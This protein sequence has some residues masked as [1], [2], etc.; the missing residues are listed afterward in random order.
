MVPVFQNWDPPNE[1]GTR[2]IK[3]GPAVSRLRYTNKTKTRVWEVMCHWLRTDFVYNFWSYQPLEFAKLWFLGVPVFK[4]WN[5][6]NPPTKTGTRKLKLGPAFA[7]AFR[8]HRNWNHNVKTRIL[9]FLD[10]FSISFWSLQTLQNHRFHFY[11]VPGLLI[12]PHLLKLGP[13]N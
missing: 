2:R 12:K 5:L 13:T 11:R 6:I 7:K 1:T 4:N 8:D 10:R 3:L 9:L